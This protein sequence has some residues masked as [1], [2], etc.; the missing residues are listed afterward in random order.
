MRRARRPDSDVVREHG[1]TWDNT[2]GCAC[3]RTTT[4]VREAALP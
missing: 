4:A 2:A 3:L 1:D